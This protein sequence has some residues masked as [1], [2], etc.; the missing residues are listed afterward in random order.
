[1]R[2]FLYC[3]GIRIKD[4]GERTHWGAV[5]VLGLR[6]REAAMKWKVG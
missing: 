2:G 3:W 4:F 6:L 1:M 5:I